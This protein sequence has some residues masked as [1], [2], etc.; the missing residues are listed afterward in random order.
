M[1]LGL[2]LLRDVVLGSTLLGLANIVLLLVVNL[3]G[4]VACD[5]GNGAAES[6]RDTVSDT[7]TQVA[8]LALGLL[9]LALEVL[10]ATGLLQALSSDETA[11]GFLGRADGLVVRTLGAVGVVPGD[12]TRRR[13][14]SAGELGG[15]LRGIILLVCLV[16]LVLALSL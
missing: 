15:C 14:G 3:S 9:L 6:A 13:S 11:E 16:L 7:A 4:L 12:L 10:L 2:G 1:L 5:A 8:N